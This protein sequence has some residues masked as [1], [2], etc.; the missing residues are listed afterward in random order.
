[1][2]DHRGAPYEAGKAVV[3]VGFPL[4][5]Y[6]APQNGVSG[7]LLLHAGQ[8]RENL[9]AF[10]CGP[11][12]HPEPDMARSPIR[13]ASPRYSLRSRGSTWMQTLV[14][15]VDPSLGPTAYS[16]RRDQKGACVQAGQ[17]RG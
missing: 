2:I 9:G 17:V 11:A 4:S 8:L 13:A 7:V 6:R 1:M 15:G 3:A 5:S 10:S 12:Y 14:A 16:P